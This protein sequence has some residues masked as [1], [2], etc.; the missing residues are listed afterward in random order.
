MT[1]EEAPQPHRIYGGAGGLGSGRFE[2][3]GSHR[4]LKN[5]LT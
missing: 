1:N 3:D 2:R 4:L 5:Y